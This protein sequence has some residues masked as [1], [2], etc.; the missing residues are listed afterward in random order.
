MRNSSKVVNFGGLSST[1]KKAPTTP[2][3]PHTPASGRSLVAKTSVKKNI[4]NDTTSEDA[5]DEEL[6]S[7]LAARKRPRA[8]KAPKSYTE[9]DAT[10]GDEEEEF[11]S[12]SK[13]VRA[14]SVDNECV[15]GMTDD[16]TPVKEE[17]EAVAF[18]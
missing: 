5:M 18:V 15:A 13:R 10:T 4:D 2:R 14:K 11:T 12:M 9:S 1:P 6:L 8:S 7:P 17:D 3:T 16:H